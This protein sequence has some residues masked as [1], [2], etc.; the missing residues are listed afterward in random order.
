MTLDL[1]RDMT[2]SIRQLDIQCFFL[3][4]KFPSVNIKSPYIEWLV[5]S[6]DRNSADGKYGRHLS[7][8]IF[9]GFYI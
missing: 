6:V 4:R 9:F 2:F 7:V 3:S 8:A 1:N 5:F